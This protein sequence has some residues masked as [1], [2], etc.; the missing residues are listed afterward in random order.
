MPGHQTTK[1]FDTGLASV[2]T[3]PLNW[4]HEL[5]QD[6]GL[7]PGDQPGITAPNPNHGG[8]QED[9]NLTRRNPMFPDYGYDPVNGQYY[10]L[11]NSATGPQ[12]VQNPDVAQQVGAATLRSRC[13]R[14]SNIGR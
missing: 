14:A 3:N 9:P 6:L 11:G 5:A 1:N 4:P 13:S 2:K 8:A 12:S 7:A 10:W